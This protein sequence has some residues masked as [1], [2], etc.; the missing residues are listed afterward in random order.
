MSKNLANFIHFFTFQ[1]SID[2]FEDF[3]RCDSADSRASARNQKDVLP[4]AS[5]STT[6]SF[7]QERY[8][9]GEKKAGPR[10]G[11]L[12]LR[13]VSRLLGMQIEK[14]VISI[15]ETRMIFILFACEKISLGPRCRCCAAS[16]LR[17]AAVATAPAAS[18]CVPLR[19]ERTPS[20]RRR[21]IWSL[22]IPKQSGNSRKVKRN[23]EFLNKL[24]Y[25]LTYLLKILPFS[26]TQQR[27]THGF[28][29]RGC[30]VDAEDAQCEVFMALAHASSP[31]LGGSSTP[32]LEPELFLLLRY[33]HTSQFVLLRKASGTGVGVGYACLNAPRE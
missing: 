1:Q 4:D 28:W 21:S 8:R 33:I 29:R 16:W 22:P 27:K 32:S 25:L 5:E 24:I 31:Q 23:K 2:D 17:K 7:G 13:V 26:P 19:C 14:E 30:R 20:P 12:R 10:G 18:R 15:E 6:S 3:D 11:C 9:D